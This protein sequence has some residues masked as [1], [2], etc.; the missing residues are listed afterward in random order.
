MTQIKVRTKL[1]MPKLTRLAFTNLDEYVKETIEE[2]A[3]AWLRAALE[4]VPSWSGASRAT[5]QA[6]AAA[7]NEPVPIRRSNNAPNRVALGRLY[8]RGGINKSGQAS[9]NFYYETTLRYLVANETKKVAPRTEGLFASLRT[10][11]PYKFR[12]AGNR[13]AAAVINA[14]LATIPVFEDLLE[15]NPI[16]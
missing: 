6:L 7:V 1:E 11:T 13:A 5:F 16:Q 10:P 14:R 4:I 8:S 2:A 9:Y 15:K 3:R 12:E